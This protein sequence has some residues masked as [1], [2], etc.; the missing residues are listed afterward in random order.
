GARDFK[1]EIVGGGFRSDMTV[2]LGGGIDV[3]S[4]E[5]IDAQH[6]NVFVSIARNA[7]MGK[8]TVTISAGGQSANLDAAFTI[9]DDIPP[10]AKFTITPAEGT[11]NTTF[12]F[13][14]SGSTD[15]DGHITSYQW[16]FNDGDPVKGKRIE[17]QF[18]DIGEVSVKLTVGDDKQSFHTIEKKIDVADNAVPD[19]G[20]IVTPSAGYTITTFSF[21]ASESV[22]PDGTIR[23]YKWDFGDGKSS[24]GKKTTHKFVDGGDY[25]VVLT[26]Q[27][28]SKVEKTATRKVKVTFFDVEKAKKEITDVTVGFLKLFGDLEHL[29]AEQIVVG[30]SRN[31]TGRNREIAIIE[32]EQPIVDSN[33]VQIISDSVDAVSPT[34]GRASVTA[35]FFGRYVDGT[36]FDGVATH[37]F[38]MVNEDGEWK[39]CNFSVIKGLSP[40]LQRLFPE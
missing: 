7:D 24:T 3:T 16:T 23:S 15:T 36:D 25:S 27:D 1:L 17:R 34:N 30:F 8:R 22:D 11:I 19:A 35:R 10:T 32:T 20:F 4:K 29:S 26:V 38:T 18:A 40:S 33:N 39:I 2:S 12:V 31:C 13:D 21:D 6:A 5:L 14:A 37:D 28:S 9:G